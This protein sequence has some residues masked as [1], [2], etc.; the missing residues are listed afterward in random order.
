MSEKTTLLILAAGMGSR[1]GGLKQMDAIGPNGETIID[2]SI[3]DAIEAGFNKIVFIIRE[4]F[5]E[6][7]KNR[8]DALIPSDVEVHYV[9]QEINTPIDGVSIKTD[10]EKPWGTG[11]AVLVAKDVID[12]PFAVINADDYY[13]KGAYKL[14]YDFLN[15]HASQNHFAMVGYLLKNTIS[16]HGTV[17]RGVCKVSEEKIL[18]T[19]TER[20]KI[21]RDDSGNIYYEEQ[22]ERVVLD[23]NTIVSMNFWGFDHN[24]FKSLSQSFI[25]FAEANKDNPKSEFFIPLIVDQLIQ[26]GEVIH[27]VL[28]TDDVWYGITYQEDKEP[29]QQA[30][31][32]MIEEGKYVNI[33]TRFI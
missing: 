10:R 9:F 6:A 15:N 16:D 19:I 7:F 25:K 5:A 14:M 30:F 22:G 13:G 2:F 1:Y 8:F 24:L 17:S 28:D 31:K 33:G 18:Q 29:V 12:E 21:S 27:S 26:S 32:R 3:Y 23:D 20:T 11:H 4:H